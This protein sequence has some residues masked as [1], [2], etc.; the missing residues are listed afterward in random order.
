[1]TKLMGSNQVLIKIQKKR[2]LP[3]IAALV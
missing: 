2:I 3:T 1:M